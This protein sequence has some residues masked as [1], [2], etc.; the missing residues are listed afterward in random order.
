MCLVAISSHGNTLMKVK[1]YQ[2]MIKYMMNFALH[3]TTLTVM[4]NAKSVGVEEEDYSDIC[5]KRVIHWVSQNLFMRF[6]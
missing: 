6:G 3:K 2:K 1:A 5:R 4:N